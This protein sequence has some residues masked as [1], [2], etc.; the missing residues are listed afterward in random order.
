MKNSL[1]IASVSL[2]TAAMIA[3]VAQAEVSA[4][5]A[6]Q[7]DYTWRGISQ[8]AEDPSIQGGFDYGHESG[9]YAGVWG[10]SV[11]FGS[12]ESTELDLYLGY[13]TEFSNGIGID[14][15]AIEYTYHGSEGASDSNFTEVYAGI[16]YAGFSATY[17]A[18]DEFSDLIE[19]S[20]GYDFE[21]AGLSLGATY[22]DYD[23]YSYYTIGLSGG[24]GADSKLGWDVSFW[25]TDVD[26]VPE[27]DSRAVVT[28]SASF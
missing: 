25:D 18:G 11:D 5:V 8:N 23:E 4:N 10:A 9:F 17:Y 19:V 15:G 13:A 12:V 20:Y 6:L 24:F 7:S 3:P 14:V 28:I 27:A 1:K 26:N 2:L 16:S 21:A 22:G